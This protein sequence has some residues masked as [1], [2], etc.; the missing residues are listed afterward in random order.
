MKRKQYPFR[1]T[2]KWLLVMKLFLANLLSQKPA[3]SLSLFLI[4]STCMQTL[5]IENILLAL[6][7]LG[8][9]MFAN[10]LRIAYPVI[11]PNSVAFTCE[12][13]KRSKVGYR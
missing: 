2:P 8:L 10:K 12:A 9:V 3:R 5:F 7:I 1:V 6:I 13:L 11:L 4:T